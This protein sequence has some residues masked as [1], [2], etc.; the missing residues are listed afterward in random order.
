M[1]LH[2]YQNQL[3]S[4]DDVD[5]ISLTDWQS[6]NNRGGSVEQHIR[7]SG[8]IAVEVLE[9]ELFFL[10]EQRGFLLL[11]HFNLINFS[12]FLATG[13]LSQLDLN[14]DLPN[15]SNSASRHQF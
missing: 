8:D 11:N 9:Q 6:R 4:T 5:E 1:K 10:G 3:I 13:E 12:D 15:I 2:R 7:P 14:V